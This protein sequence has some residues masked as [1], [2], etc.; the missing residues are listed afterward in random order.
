MQGDRVGHLPV[1]LPACRS[2]GRCPSASS[3]RGV[4][5]SR[6]CR[7]S[8]PGPRAGRRCCRTRRCPAAARAPGVGA[9]GRGLVPGA[10]VHLRVLVVQPPRV[11]AM[12]SARPVRRRVLENGALN[13]ATPRRDAAARSIWFTPMQNAPMASRPGA[14]PSTRSVI[15]VPDDTEPGRGARRSANAWPERLGRRLHLVAVLDQ[16]GGGIGVNVLQQQDSGLPIRAVQRQRSSGCSATTAHQ[17]IR[18]PG[19]TGLQASRPP[20]A[21]PRGVGRPATSPTG[22][23][24]PPAWLA[25]SMSWATAAP[26]SAATPA[27][28]GC[29]RQAR[30]R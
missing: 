14:A 17:P 7:G 5:K 13:T 25:S 24:G 10:R 16:P 19:V 29:R 8:R 23:L 2:A 3:V 22:A 28:G 30:L 6:S 26:G 1:A 18:G 27:P 11:S 12:I 9:A 15:L 20:R 4:E 21:R